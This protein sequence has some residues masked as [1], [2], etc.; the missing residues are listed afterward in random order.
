[1][2]Y[3]II[4][5]YIYIYIYTYIYKYHNSHYNVEVMLRAVLC[6]YWRQQ[7]IGLQLYGH[8]PPMTK[9]IKVGRDR[10]A[11]HCWRSKDKLISDVLQWN[12][13][14]C[15]GKTVRPARTYIQQLCEDTGYSPE[16]Q[17]EAM[18]DREEWW[19]RVKDI[20]AG[21]TTRWWWGW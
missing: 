21:G 8:Q 11:G 5:I 14:H 18:K 20:H 10:H 2:R 1:M 7:L 19:E 17:A 15:Q 12:P 16:D 6:G 9:T 13:S 4:Y 3:F